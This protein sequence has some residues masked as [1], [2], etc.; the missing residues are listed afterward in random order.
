MKNQRVNRRMEIEFLVQL[1]KFYEDNYNKYFVSDLFNKARFET[2]IEAQEI[3]VAHL[4]SD[5]IEEE[6][7]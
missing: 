3:K 2:V 5:I 6:E 1:Y 4:F 7:E